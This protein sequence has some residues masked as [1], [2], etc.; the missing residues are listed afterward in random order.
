LDNM[1]NYIYDPGN[2]MT[3]EQTFGIAQYLN[4]PIVGK[5]FRILNGHTQVNANEVYALPFPDSKKLGE[6]GALLK[7]KA[8]LTSNE[9]KGL[10][11]LIGITQSRVE[12]FK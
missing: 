3:K 5:Y 9:Q 1:L 4:L 8:E 6:M 10:M 2:R 11:Q 7:D 12:A